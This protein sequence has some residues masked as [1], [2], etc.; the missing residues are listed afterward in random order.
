MEAIKAG[1]AWYG[2]EYVDACE[3][4]APQS[5]PQSCGCWTMLA[6]AIKYGLDF[7]NKCSVG[8]L[9]GPIAAD[10]AEECCKLIIL[11]F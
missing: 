7:D 1:V 6:E 5:D 10:L 11:N 9:D 4:A 8:S 3:E 2:Q